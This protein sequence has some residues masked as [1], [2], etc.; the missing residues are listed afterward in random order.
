FGDPLMEAQAAAG[1]YAIDQ[2]LRI[3]TVREAVAGDPCPVGS[4]EEPRGSDQMA[5][6]RQLLEALLDG[7][8]VRVSTDGDGWLGKLVAEHARH[9]EDALRLGLEAV[10]LLA[11]QLPETLR[12]GAGDL[13]ERLAQTPAFLFLYQHAKGDELVH[14]AHHEQRVAVRAQV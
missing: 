5:L 8:R 2:G 6:P 13:V 11:D 4:N 12:N 3:Q 1:R 10:D 7:G 9:F 14:D